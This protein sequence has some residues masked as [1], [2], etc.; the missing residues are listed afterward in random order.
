MKTIFPA[1]ILILVSYFANAQTDTEAFIKKIP[2]IPKD[3][4]GITRAAVESF[5]QKVNVLIDQVD[6]E[7]RG[8]NEKADA[9][10]PTTEAAAK[11]AAMKQMSQKY[12]LSQDEMNKMKSGKM[13]ATEKKEMANKILQLQTNM[14]MGEVQNLSK[15]SSAGKKA[16]AEAYATEAQAMGQANPKQH[17]SNQDANT[18]QLASEQQAVMADISAAGQKI[19]NLYAT[20]DSDPTGPE[21]LKKIENWHNKLMS[22]TGVDYGQGKKMDSIAVLIKNEQV[23]YCAK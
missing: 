21:M 23:R 18:Y 13:S 19:G 16:Y 11:D 6:E 3:S 14:S 8:L 4:C 17:S 15:M 5:S 1:F 12:G 7:I 10:A 9:Q 20:I 22:M 2:A